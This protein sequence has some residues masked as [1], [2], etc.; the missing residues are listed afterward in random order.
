M[1][2]TD[3][4]AQA[5]GEQRTQEE[6]ENIM[7]E[8]RDELERDRRQALRDAQERGR[9]EKERKQK[10]EERFRELKNEL[11]NY[12]FQTSPRIKKESFRG[13]V[14]DDI[15]VLRVALIGTPGS[16]KTSLVGKNRF[17][18]HVT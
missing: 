5:Q 10:E 18:L 12:D 16:G 13:L 6:N 15:D 3:P 1:D 2:R 4:T 8:L 11:T 14:V 9:E 7:R 17:K